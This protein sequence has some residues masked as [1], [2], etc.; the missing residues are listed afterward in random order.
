[1]PTRDEPLFRLALFALLLAV[2]LTAG[3]WLGRAVGP[4]PGPVPAD[5]GPSMTH[6][7][8]MS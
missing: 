5:H 8:G 2:V 4:R 6:T 3:F 1:M 7:G